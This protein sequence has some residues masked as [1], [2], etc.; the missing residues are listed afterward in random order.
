MAS[1]SETT[2]EVQEAT[3][4]A[5][6]LG[7]FGLRGD[8]FA[9]QLVNFLL[10]LLVLWRFAYKPIMKMLEE[11]E[12][13][14][15]KSVVDAEKIEHR[16]RE[17]EVERDSL[18]LAARKEAQEIVITAVSQSEER[19]TEM[20]D[21]A[22]REVERVISK[23]KQQLEL[24][25]EAILKEARKDMVDIAMKAAARI[26]HTGIDEAK[27]QSLAEEVVRKMT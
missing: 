11:R 5:A 6:V 15:S 9:A 16:V 2:T 26:L 10:V 25:K 12:A 1:N 21:A 20:L 8:L 14:I 19:K 13:K 23:G 18:L 3:G 22:K 24:D 27:S 4:P 17:F 7:A